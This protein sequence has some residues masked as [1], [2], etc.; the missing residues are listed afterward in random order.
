MRQSWRPARFLWQVA[1]SRRERRVDVRLMFDD[2]VTHPPDSDQLD[3]AVTVH[4]V[5]FGERPVTVSMIGL[6][7]SN[8]DGEVWNEHSKPEREVPP[9][10][11][12]SHTTFAGT[13]PVDLEIGFVEL[14][15]RHR[16]AR[17][18]REPAHALLL[19]DHRQSEPN[20][21]KLRAPPASGRSQ[22]QHGGQCT[23]TVSGTPERREEVA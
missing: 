18:R 11:R 22:Q 14:A 5:N 13:M 2:A 3:L 21:P 4:A 7:G 16:P 6:L 10:A 9:G 19:Q 20:Q 8:D 12:E 1:R 17:P 23:Q 15:M